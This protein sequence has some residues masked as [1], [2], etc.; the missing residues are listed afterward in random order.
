MLLIPRK[1][2]PTRV[3]KGML[4]LS[5][6][7]TKEARGKALYAFMEKLVDKL[8]HALFYFLFVINFA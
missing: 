6:Y 2:V 1:F 5:V 8:E 4:L 7:S 3:T